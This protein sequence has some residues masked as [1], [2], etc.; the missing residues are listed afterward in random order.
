MT[1]PQQW[2]NL[3]GTTA[4]DS[5]GAKVGKIGQFYVNDATG[6]PAWATVSTGFFGTRESLAPLDGAEVNDGELHLAVTKQL[7]KDAPNIDADGHLA[8]DDVDALYQHY[9]DFFNRTAAPA[10]T[11]STGYDTPE[12]GLAG[13]GYAEQND[14]GFAGENQ[15]GFAGQNDAGLAGRNETGLAGQAD[16][17]F[18]DRDEAAAGSVAWSTAA[19]AAGYD[20]SDR[21]ADGTVIR[22]EE[23]LP[24]GST[25][26][27]SV[28][29]GRVRL[30]RYVVTEI[31]T[32]DVP[33]SPAGLGTAAGQPEAGE[34]ADWEQPEEPGAGRDER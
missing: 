26:S 21:V 11:G 22:S 29:E 13:S 25:G 10:G 30:R 8:G 23:V 5:E 6:E 27:D 19:P 34:P 4:L 20:T 2:D 14:A 24:P 3:V 33:A 12:P 9:G 31:I 17:G 32:E 1:T 18:A 15:T 7:V 28:P 16:T